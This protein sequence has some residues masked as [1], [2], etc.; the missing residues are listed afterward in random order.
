MKYIKLGLPIF[1]VVACVWC[2]VLSIME[3]NYMGTMGYITALFG[4]LSIAYSEYV[5]FRIQNRSV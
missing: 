1:V 2:L 5:D 4:W 3:T